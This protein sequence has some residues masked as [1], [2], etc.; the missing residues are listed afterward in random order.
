MDDDPN[1]IAI[2]APYKDEDDYTRTALSLPHNK[3]WHVPARRERITCD[4]GST[5]PPERPDDVAQNTSAVPK[6]SHIRLGFDNLPLEGLSFGSDPT[7]SI[8]LGEGTDPIVRGISRQHFFITYREDGRLIVTDTS[9]FGTTVTY[10]KFE[11]GQ[12]EQDCTTLLEVKG[13]DN[14]LDNVRIYV[15]CQGGI[16]IDIR[17]ASHRNSMAEFIRKKNDFLHRRRTANPPVAS[18]RLGIYSYGTMQKSTQYHTTKGIQPLIP[19]RVIGKGGFGIV[20]KLVDR[21]TGAPYALKASTRKCERDGFKFLREI[22]L[23]MRIKHV[24]QPK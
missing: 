15:P 8:L 4:R 6:G 14:K 9:Q 20:T 18:D 16:Q 10:G 17:V 22:R 11:S 2:L 7:C 13:H 3:F 21:Y 24:G 23:M 5:P 12:P 19:Q 1:L